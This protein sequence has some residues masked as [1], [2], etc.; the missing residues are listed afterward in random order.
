MTINP[1][2]DVILPRSQFPGWRNWPYELGNETLLMASLEEQALERKARLKALRAKKEGK[3][4]TQ[5][6]DYERA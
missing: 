2:D 5:V 1:N 4:D 6:R 3:Q